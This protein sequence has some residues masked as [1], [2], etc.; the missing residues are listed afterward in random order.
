MDVNSLILK[1][2]G[3]SVVNGLN[4]YKAL[5]ISSDCIPDIFIATDEDGYRCLLLFLPDNIDIKINGADKE[6]LNLTYLKDKNTILIRLKDSDFFDLFN[7]LII[8]LYSKIE[9]ISDPNIYSN[10]LIF[11]FYKWSEFFE[12]KRFSKLTPEKIKG[13]IGE[14]IVLNDLLNQCETQNVNLVLESW[15]GP[16]DN[17]NDFVFDDK[18]IE[19]K[20]KEN[21]QQLIKISSEFQ[22]ECEFDKGLELIIVSVKVDL[23]SGVSI[24][25]LLSQAVSTI[26]YKLG[27]LSILYNTINQIGLTIESSKEYNNYRFVIVKVST[28]NCALPTFPKLTFSNI[29]N[30]ITNLNYNLR[31]SSLNDFLTSEKKY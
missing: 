13:L 15:K 19:V 5:R 21:S 22:L 8:S 3:I 1:W 26:R 30:E 25:D 28:Y 12:D 14:L 10:E 2:E 16:F 20:A 29:P 7:D 27:D 4:G 17:S 9:K 6:K 23:I 31:M 11:T 18:N 24:N